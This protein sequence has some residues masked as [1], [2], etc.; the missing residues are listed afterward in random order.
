MNEKVN[1]HL[2]EINN[3]NKIIK[4]LENKN[5]DLE[6]ELMEIKDQKENCY[7]IITELE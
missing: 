2:E 7:S 1:T 4:E 3:K 5:E 6:D